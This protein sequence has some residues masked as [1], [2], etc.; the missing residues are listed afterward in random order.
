MH[1]TMHCGQPSPVL[2][3]ETPDPL[4]YPRKE[5]FYSS[6]INYHVSLKN[7]DSDSVYKR[8]KPSL[9]LGLNVFGF[10]HSFIHSFEFIHLNLFI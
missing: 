9:I 10:I 5:C 7:S 6:V 1:F 4:Q 8:N 2:G 3:D